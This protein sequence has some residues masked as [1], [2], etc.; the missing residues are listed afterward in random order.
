MHHRL[1]KMGRPELYVEDIN[2]AQIYEDQRGRCMHCNRTL[3][4]Y[5]IDHITPLADGGQHHTAT[6]QLLCAICHGFKSKRDIRMRGANQQSALDYLI[7]QLAAG[8][9]TS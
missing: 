6:V 4:R 5:E 1:T 3:D 2:P 7:E 8:V 9:R